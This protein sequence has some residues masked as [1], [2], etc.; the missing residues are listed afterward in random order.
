MRRGGVQLQ[1][2]DAIDFDLKNVM[3]N[4]YL[5]DL[6][7]GTPPQTMSVIVDTGSSDLWVLS[8]LSEL[9][10]S[11]LHLYDQLSSST[12][13]GI[14]AR[15]DLEFL[16]G[17][18]NGT[19]AIESVGM[20]DLNVDKQTFVQV[21]TV[22]SVFTDQFGDGEAFD[23]IVGMAFQSFSIDGAPTLLETMYNEGQI[24]EKIFSF[25]LNLHTEASRLLIGEPD[26]ALLPHGVTYI[27]LTPL[28][29]GAQFLVD[30]Y[31]F[32]GFSREDLWM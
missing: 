23:G 31:G 13:E 30:E 24:S 4:T 25:Y 11:G 26:K 27:P 5:I 6:E 12:F 17:V 32:H 19:T 3:D 8:V 2:T 18:V 7:F 28:R 16:A 22:D 1:A 9:R 10:F 29:N 21:D 20:G 15:V 14:G